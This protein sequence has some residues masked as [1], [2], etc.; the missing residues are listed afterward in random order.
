MGYFNFILLFTASMMFCF[1]LI[2][3]GSKY[4][5]EKLELNANPRY[6]ELRRFI[7]PE[8]SSGSV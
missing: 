5:L 6:E 8:K 2:R 7:S 1:I 3:M 4:L